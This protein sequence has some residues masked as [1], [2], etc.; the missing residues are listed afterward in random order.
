MVLLHYSGTRVQISNK[1]R[2][3]DK[4]W[5]KYNTKIFSWK[6]PNHNFVNVK[7]AIFLTKITKNSITKRAY[8]NSTLV[9]YR[10]TSKTFP[11]ISMIKSKQI[12]WTNGHTKNFAIYFCNPLTNFAISPPL[13]PDHLMNFASFLIFP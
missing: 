3:I 13:P 1:P 10:V 4:S 12:P 2:C 6:K 7:L 11:A 5:H 8:T 9:Y